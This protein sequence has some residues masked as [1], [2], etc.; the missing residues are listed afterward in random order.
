MIKTLLVWPH[1]HLQDLTSR[2]SEQNGGGTG[3]FSN[4]CLDLSFFDSGEKSSFGFLARKLSAYDS[5]D[6]DAR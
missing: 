4:L 1:Y 6:A 2:P 5:S 3:V